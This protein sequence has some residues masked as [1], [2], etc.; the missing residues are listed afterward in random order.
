MTNLAKLGMLSA[1]EP[2][3]P[4]GSTQ[5]S[6]VPAGTYASRLFGKP[7]QINK[8]VGDELQGTLNNLGDDLTIYLMHRDDEDFIRFDAIRRQQT[9]VLSIMKALSHPSLA[10]KYWSIGWSNWQ[11]DRV[12]ESVQLANRDPRLIRPSFNSA[13]FSL[14]EMSRRS[15]HAGGVQVS[16]NEM[17]DPNFQRG[18]LQNPYSPLGGFSI[19]DKPEPRWENAKLDAKAKF[20][21]GDAYWQNV[22]HSIFTPANEARYHRV[23][24]FTKKFNQRHR[25]NYSVDQMIN[26]YALAHKRTDFLTVGPITV[27]QLRRTVGALRL[28]RSL[29][30]KDLAYLYRGY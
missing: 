1:D 6:D 17:M 12:E 15:I 26:A 13:Y 5:L 25:T 19:L 20:D 30:A 7:L 24:S 9:P 3:Q 11:T 16:H 21:A 22:Y 18:V 8:R 14:F 27:E 10:N 4:D 28:A 23:E 29:T 2:I